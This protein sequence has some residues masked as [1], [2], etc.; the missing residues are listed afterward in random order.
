M[1]KTNPG[2]FFEDYQIGQVIRHAVPRTV[3]EG[4]R[5]LY[6]ALYPA[7]HALYSSDEFAA[8]CG[9]ES[10]PIDD[11]A[12]FHIVFGKTVPDISLNA[13]ANLGYGEGRWLRPVWPGDTLRAESQ[14]IGLKQNSSGKSG[15]VWVRTRGL[16]QMDEPVLE[17]VRW[18]MVHKRDPEAPAPE[19][20]VPDLAAAV[21]TAE[22]QLPE[23]LNFS[24]YDFDLA[25]EKHRLADYELGE[26]I[27]HVDG[28][29]LE[30][31]EH[32]LAT[33]LW[34]NTAKVHFDA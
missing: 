19:T 26:K 23:D 13:V 9:L 32:M 27:D 16:N 22:L 11:L 21:P 30:E 33:R 1:T 17:Y 7:R 18:V 20:V 3:A 31:A 12:A 28:V 10:S 25:G 5:A 6:H 29:T 15:V 2:R 34:Q 14:V 4:E 8:S 24:D